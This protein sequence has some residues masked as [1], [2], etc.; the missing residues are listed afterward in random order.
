MGLGRIEDGTHVLAL[1]PGIAEARNCRRRI[2]FQP[3]G[4]C[5]IAPGLCHDMG[6]VARA[7]LRLIGL[8]DRIDRRRIDQPLLRQHRLQRLHPRLHVRIAVVVMM[9]V[10]MIRMIVQDEALRA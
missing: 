5:R 7:D 6:A 3:F 9:M 1:S 4:E 8:D 2:A 10:I